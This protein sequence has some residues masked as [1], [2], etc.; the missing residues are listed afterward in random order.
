MAKEE[1]ELISKKQVIDYLEYKIAQQRR[2]LSESKS[3]YQRRLESYVI[4]N[5]EDIKLGIS[6]MQ[7]RFEKG[8]TEKMT[9]RNEVAM[10]FKKGLID[11]K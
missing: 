3:E 6:Y 8:E 2:L 10:D 1:I 7:K 5:L 9:R 4:A 11:L